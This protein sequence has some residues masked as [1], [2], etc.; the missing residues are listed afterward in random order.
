MDNSV[1]V[2]NDFANF[3]VQSNIGMII[4]ANWDI[5]EGLPRPQRASA[6]RARLLSLWVGAPTCRY[7]S[8]LMADYVL[9][10]HTGCT[11]YLGRM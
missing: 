11:S 10:P 2:A 9:Q 1:F 6:S 5:D 3:F 4:R 7:P 8:L